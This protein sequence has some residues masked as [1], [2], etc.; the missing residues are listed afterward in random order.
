MI[1]SE[2]NSSRALELLLLIIPNAIPIVG[3][4]YYH[5]EVYQLLISYWTEL[6]VIGVFGALRIGL[7]E[8]K[9]SELDRQMILRRSDTAQIDSPEFTAKW[10]L[11]PNYCL[12]TIGLS[13][14][15]GFVGIVT[16]LMERQ[17]SIENISLNSFLPAIFIPASFYL[18]K[19]GSIF[20][21]NFLKHGQHK[22]VSPYSQIAEPIN[23]FITALGL[24]FGLFLVLLFTP[25]RERV[26]ILSL[27]IVFFIIK[28]IVELSQQLKLNN[29]KP[30]Q[31]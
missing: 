31:G 20:V 27:A 26:Y 23:K 11:L 2:T 7:A 16:R 9:L 8:G 18:V 19:H 28:S 3:L 17:E 29:S 30:A 13:V 5:W 24:L 22:S 15:L 1:G 6:V 25:L 4:L 21:N 10:Y 12:V 14:F